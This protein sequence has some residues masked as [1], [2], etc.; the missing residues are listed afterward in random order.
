MSRGEDSGSVTSLA[1]QSNQ[2]VTLLLSVAVTSELTLF[3]NPP[4]LLLSQLCTHFSEY[5]QT[6]SLSTVLRADRTENSNFIAGTCLPNHRV[7]TV[8]TL[9]A[10][11]ALV[12]FL[13]AYQRA[14]STRTSI[15]ACVLTCLLS[16][17]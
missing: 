10:V 14:I 6:N 2:Y 15:V 9:T 17:C 1:K 16:R 8:A 13:G 4:V 5:Y 7:V 11:H 3:A 12:R